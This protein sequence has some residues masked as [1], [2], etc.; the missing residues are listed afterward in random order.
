MAIL[1][2]RNHAGPRSAG[3]I[4][5]WLEARCAENA[6]RAWSSMGSAHE[7]MCDSKVVR[8]TCTHDVTLAMYCYVLT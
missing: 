2:L 5:F 8:R 6:A 3:D 7:G 4:Q 1:N